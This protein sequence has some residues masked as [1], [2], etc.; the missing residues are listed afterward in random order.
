MAGSRRSREAA[1][2]AHSTGR[3]FTSSK[4][5]FQA[6][7]GSEMHWSQSALVA[8]MAQHFDFALGWGKSLWGRLLAVGALIRCSRTF[9]RRTVV[10]KRGSQEPLVFIPGNEPCPESDDWIQLAAPDHRSKGGDRDASLFF[11]LSEAICPAH[12]GILA[13]AGCMV[14]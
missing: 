2:R 3:I 1:S 9:C 7:A 13:P 10:A 11:D 5:E 4:C 6:Q 12:T 8:L 14:T